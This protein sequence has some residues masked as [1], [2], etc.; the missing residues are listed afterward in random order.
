MKIADLKRFA[1]D[2]RR[3]GI[4]AVPHEGELLN[5]VKIGIH[6]FFFDKDGKYD[7]WGTSHVADEPRGE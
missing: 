2:L 3:V 4:E 6:D 5:R 1:N 7:G